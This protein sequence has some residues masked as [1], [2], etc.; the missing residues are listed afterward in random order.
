MHPAAAGLAMA[1]FVIDGIVGVLG[2][3]ALAGAVLAP[4]AP[5]HIAA[6][7]I[8]NDIA[9]KADDFAALRAKTLQFGAAL[10]RGVEDTTLATGSLGRAAALLPPEIPLAVAAGPD[11]APFNAAA[12]FYRAGDVANGDALATGIAEPVQRIALEWLA[13]RFAAHPSY[14]RLA[15][16]GAAH[17]DWPAMTW[18][19]QTQEAL[20]YTLAPAPERVAAIFDQDAP[21]TPPGKLALA[22]AMTALGRADDATTLVRSLWR[23]SDFD[24]WTE[25]AVLKDFGAILTRDDHKHR[26]DRLS[27]LASAQAQAQALHAAELAGPEELAFAKLRAETLRGPFKPAASG[28]AEPSLIFARAQAARRSD[29]P[30][31]AAALLSL[32]P[33]DGALL[34]DADAWWAEERRVA[35]QL[36]DLNEF[37]KAYAL[38]AQAIPVS[39][40]SRIDAAFLAGWIALRYLQDA[41]TAAKHFDRAIESAATP[42]SIARSYYWRG[43]AAEALGQGADAAY[44][45]A[46]AAAY[47]I[48]Y[49]GQLAAKKLDAGAVVLKAP[50]R[51]AAGEE[52]AEAVRVVELLYSA[53]LVAYGQP[54][55]YDAARAMNDETQLA[56]LAQV[57]ID[58]ADALATLTIGKIA[59]TRGYALDEAAFPDF[60]VPQFSPLAHSADRAS[61]FAIARQESEFASAAHSG[62]GAKGLMQLLPSTAS[63]TARRAGVGFT[64]DR[65]IS[66]PAYN[67]QLGAEYFGALRESEQGSDILAFAAYNAGAGRVAQWIKAYGDPRTGEV[68]LVDWV[69]RLPF[70]ETR[71]YVQRVSENLGVYRA[72]FSQSAKDAVTSLRT[73]ALRGKAGE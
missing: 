5:S 60:G 6:P 38:C 72:R 17:R 71:D 49:Y 18:L 67:A 26:A 46:Y 2:A 64:F 4:N 61:V 19:R 65:L 54:L 44:D 11:L 50:S 21:R 15:A 52:R 23:A 55:A 66:D 31:E 24:A 27:Y 56:A 28:P 3:L 68:D 37:K 69:E 25:S 40:S 45:F 42:L 22:R 48:T 73:A 39:N 51:T 62:A 10:S 70:D 32:A 20:I 29:H 47:P 14:E 13:L 12:T 58:H 59:T 35:R 7:F 33:S 16:F 63:E 9:M 41:P 53:G 43:R 36:L 1:V 34:I 8:F 57:T 30:L